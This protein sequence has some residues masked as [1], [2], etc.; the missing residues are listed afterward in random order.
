MGTSR[1]WC[2]IN[3]STNRTK[4]YKIFG[5]FTREISKDLISNRMIY[6]YFSYRILRVNLVFIENNIMEILKNKN[7]I[8]NQNNNVDNKK[9]QNID[10][11]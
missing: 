3:S 10:Q 4:I 7:V 11:M 9:K 5:K 6:R 1:W 8:W 2:T